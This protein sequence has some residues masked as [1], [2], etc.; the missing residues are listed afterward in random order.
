VPQ[1]AK[2]W[3]VSAE[4]AL[5]KD[6]IAPKNIFLSIS[7]YAHGGIPYLAI[8]VIVHQMD[9]QT[10]QQKLEPSLAM[11]RC[12]ILRKPFSPIKKPKMK[13]FLRPG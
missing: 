3:L 12:L 8:L 7:L 9:Q 5:K 10:V 4:F 13:L 11:I 6:K 1:H 2:V